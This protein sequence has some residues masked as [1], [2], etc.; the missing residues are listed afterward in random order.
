MKYLLCSIKDRSIDAFQPIGSMRAEGEAIRG[1]QDALNNP[2][3]GP[4]YKHPDDFDLY[5]LGELDDETGTIT[6]C[7]PRK[8]ADGKQ[9][10]I[11]RDA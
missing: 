11:E 6:P 2:N 10:K 7:T 9:L 3:N 4:I 8:I 1:F 5:V